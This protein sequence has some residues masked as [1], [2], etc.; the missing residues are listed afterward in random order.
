MSAVD[1]EDTMPRLP[2][3]VSS[4]AKAVMDGYFV[5]DKTL[6]IRDVID[7]G[8]EV[9][10]FTRPRR[11]GKTLNMDMLRRFFEIPVPPEGDDVVICD[12][13]T[14]FRD[15]DIASC[16]EAYLRHRGDYPVVFL[17]FKDVK[18]P[19]WQEARN[20]LARLV[21]DEYA[22][23]APLVRRERL[24][25]FESEQFDRLCAGTS[26][27]VELAGSLK[28]LT[29]LLRESTGSPAIVIIDEYDAPIQQGHLH[30]YYDAA[31]GFMRVFFSGAFKDNANLFKGFMTGVLHVAKE[32]ILSGLNNLYV[33][34]VLDEEF[35]QYFGFTADEV[36]DMAA[37]FDATE[38]YG[39][40]CAWYDG[41]RFGST[42]V[43]NPWSVVNYFSKGCR[44]QPYWVSTSNNS[45]LGEI[46][47]AAP[48]SLLDEL[49]S[50]IEG[51]TVWTPIEIG[52]VYPHI[53]DSPSSVWSYL[54]MTGYLNAVDSIQT[55]IGS[56]LYRVAIPNKEVGLVYRTE[57]LASVR[58]VLPEAQVGLVQRAVVTGDSTGLENALGDLLERVVSVRDPASE[59]FYHGFVLGL[60][61]MLDG[62]GY[63]VRSNRESGRGFFDVALEPTS[64]RLPGVVMEFKALRGSDGGAEGPDARLDGL[65]KDALAQV[66]DRDYVCEMRA[67]G[68]ATVF[69]YGVAFQGKRVR[70]R[71]TV[72]E[73]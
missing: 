35:S 3:G 33:D 51:G 22:R 67:A 73:L 14:L 52:T 16:G 46:L 59:G 65:A 8:A 23:L 62:M 18:F 55:P 44:A 43:F 34:S 24:T 40:I 42:E 63:R 9:I 39:E 56:M 64:S 7:N 31:V 13:A 36:R 37:R 30:G 1:N 26:S 61:A 6:L 57:V 71:R 4:Y 70:V 49:R 2:L 69:A 41:Y 48:S 54:V 20:E 58:D 60:V 17:T 68:V 27:D 38:R 21:A 50:L 47:A 29:R 25:A 5:V 12:A 11:F 32:G 28:L 72:L 15:T 45:I 19:T 10:L 53:A 66:A